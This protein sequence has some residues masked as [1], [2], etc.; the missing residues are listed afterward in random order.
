MRA[1]GLA[2]GF[3]PGSLTRSIRQ[4]LG[5]GG[6]AAHGFNNPLAGTCWVLGAGGEQHRAEDLLSCCLQ[7]PRLHG[8]M[9]LQVNT[10]VQ[11]VVKGMRGRSR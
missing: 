8:Q 1:G 9:I 5:G 3:R 7:L 11:T 10:Q 2:D 6:S 4:E